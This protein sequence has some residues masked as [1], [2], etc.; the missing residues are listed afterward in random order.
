MSMLFFSFLCHNKIENKSK[1]LCLFLEELCMKLRGSPP[2]PHHQM[3]HHTA[4]PCPTL[5]SSYFFI[6]SSF[7]K[8]SSQKS[9]QNV[10]IQICLPFQNYRSLPKRRKETWKWK[11]GGLDHL[12][13]ERLEWGHLIKAEN[14]FHIFY[15]YKYY[16][17]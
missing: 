12:N 8:F 6:S 11:K 17:V 5:P 16:V 2:Q 14:Y 9:E 4:K 15:N 7:V 10:D 13:L 3:N 1:A